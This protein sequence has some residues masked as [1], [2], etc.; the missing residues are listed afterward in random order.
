M[1]AEQSLS[2]FAASIPPSD[3]QFCVRNLVRH[4]FALTSTC[5]AIVRLS[6]QPLVLLK[7]PPQRCVFVA[8]PVLSISQHL[9]ISANTFLFGFVAAYPRD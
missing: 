5:G 3:S 8:P 1:P 2:A 9:W 7:P 4:S 6:L